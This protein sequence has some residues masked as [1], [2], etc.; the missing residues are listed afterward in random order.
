MIGVGSN[1]SQARGITRDGLEDTFAVDEFTVAWTGSTF[2]GVGSE[3]GHTS[4]VTSGVWG[5][6]LVLPEN[7]VIVAS[8][9]VVKASAETGQARGIAVNALTVEQFETFRALDTIIGRG[10]VAIV[11]GVVAN[12][13]ILRRIRAGVE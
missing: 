2:I 7:F 4:W 9:T 6:T 13:T 1:A 3:A 8:Q 10:A 12:R 5:D 11:A